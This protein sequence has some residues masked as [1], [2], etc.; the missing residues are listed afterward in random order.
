MRIAVFC[1]QN[2]VRTGEFNVRWESYCVAPGGFM[3]LLSIFPCS[4]LVW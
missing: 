3:A 2:I 1:K 4:Y